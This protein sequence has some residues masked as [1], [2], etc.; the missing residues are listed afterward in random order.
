MK[1][2]NYNCLLTIFLILFLLFLLVLLYFVF[3]KKTFSLIEGKKK[4]NAEK[5]ANKK[6]ENLGKGL[7]IIESI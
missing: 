1:K 3:Y 2:N 6:K 7:G 5:E 4:Y